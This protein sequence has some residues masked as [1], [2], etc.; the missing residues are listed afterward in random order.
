MSALLFSHF[1]VANMKLMKEKNS[2]NITASKAC[3]FVSTYV[4]FI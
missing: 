1:R 3:F 4:I 2:L